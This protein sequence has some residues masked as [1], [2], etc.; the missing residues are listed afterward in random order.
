MI[1]GQIPDQCMHQPYISSFIF[2]LVAVKEMRWVVIKKI[3]DEDQISKF[4]HH[5]DTGATSIDEISEKL[6]QFGVITTSNK[7]G[8][9]M[10]VYSMLLKG[11]FD[12]SRWIV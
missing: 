2:F 12:F 1:F 9:L 3:F 8:A 10:S 11:N 5:I 6:V 7:I 4:H